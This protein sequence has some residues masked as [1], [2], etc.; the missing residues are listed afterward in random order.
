MRLLGA[1]HANARALPRLEA[2]GAA[3]YFAGVW[4]SLTTHHFPSLRTQVAV[5]R[6]SQTGS[7][8]SSILANPAR[9]TYPTEVISLLFVQNRFISFI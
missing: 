7:L 1:R 4:C 2:P 9:C 6:T 8:R 3:S 5:E